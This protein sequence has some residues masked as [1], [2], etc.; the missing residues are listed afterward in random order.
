MLCN[1]ATSQT[2]SPP[3][4]R[5]ECRTEYQRLP[6]WRQMAVVVTDDDSD[7]WYDPVAGPIVNHSQTTLDAAICNGAAPALGPSQG[8]CGSGAPSRTPST[9]RSWARH[10]SSGSPSPTGSWPDR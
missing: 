9:R 4:L 7:G 8:R 1:R 3:H 5:N 10:R 2:T 6:E